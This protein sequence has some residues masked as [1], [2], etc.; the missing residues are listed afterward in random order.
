MPP[1]RQGSTLGCMCEYNVVLQ[2]KFSCFFLIFWFC[3][4]CIF[5]VTFNKNPQMLIHN[6]TIDSID[7]VG[8]SN[9][10]YYIL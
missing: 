2:I 4:V 10:I 3:L 8:T 5:C 9:W 6:L 1:E 7:L